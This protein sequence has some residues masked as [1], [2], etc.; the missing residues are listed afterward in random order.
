[1]FAC[2]NLMIFILL[3]LSSKYFKDCGFGR[4]SFST[5]SLDNFEN[6]DVEQMLRERRP[7]F[8]NTD[9]LLEMMAKTRDERRQRILAK[10]PDATTV[11]K[12]YPCFLDM[13]ATVRA[14]L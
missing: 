3:S 14:K 11:I 5:M 10:M 2:H 4:F 6:E 13:N 8:E 1:M 12:R 7:T 9:E